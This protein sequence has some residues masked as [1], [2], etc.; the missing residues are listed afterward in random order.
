VAGRI[1]V[2]GVALRTKLALRAEREGWLNLP[3]E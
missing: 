2:I 1:A 3:A